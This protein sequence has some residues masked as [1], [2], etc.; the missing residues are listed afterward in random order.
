MIFCPNC[1]ADMRFDP[2]EQ[3][4]VCDYCGTKLTVE[5]ARTITA[6]LAEEHKDP[7]VN[8]EE[9]LQE[10]SG[11]QQELS[12][13][14]S[15]QTQQEKDSG[16]Q[17]YIYT[18]PQC[19]G[20]LLTTDDT[21]ATF[22]SYCGASVLLERRISRQ[23]RPDTILPFRK[24]KEDCEAA[25]RKFLGRTICLPKEVRDAEQI[26]KF[27]GIYMPYWLYDFRVQGHASGTGHTSERRGDFIYTHYYR[28]DTSVDGSFS[29]IGYDASSS[30]NDALS[31]AIEPFPI[32]EALPFEVSYLSG[33]YADTA[34]V[35]AAL[36]T[37]EAADQVRE[38]VGSRLAKE[39]AYSRHGI[40]AGEM[41]G[42]LPVE[43]TGEKLAYLPVWF[44]ASRSRDGS[45]VS[46]AVMN[47]QTGKLT[48]ELPVDF[49]KYLLLSLIPSLLLFIVFNFFLT[50]TP[51][52]LLGVSMLLALA[53]I[54]ISG[55]QMNQIYT[56]EHKLDDKGYQSAYGK[57]E[58][59]KAAKEPEKAVRAAETKTVSWSGKVLSLSV[60]V[61]LGSLALLFSIEVDSGLE[62]L[63]FGVTGISFLIMLL[64]FLATRIEKKL[65]R[66]RKKKASS[67]TLHS[68]E[69][70]RYQLLPGLGILAGAL[71]FFLAPAG[72]QYYYGAAG[73]IMLLTI[74]AFLA[75]VKQYN[76]LVSNPLPQFGKRGGD[77]SEI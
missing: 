29:G 52:V 71:V 38:H 17:T 27:R 4:L 60:L 40:D 7:S 35:P 74:L 53:A 15:A 58:D 49:R 1:K 2:A 36:Y 61:F 39:A 51:S 11:L 63:L 22:C 33:F 14:E 23:R 73:I 28:A 19:G 54:L 46:Y 72:D 59:R 26:D 30:F 25:Y 65:R 50:M 68:P 56:K 31:E 69:A 21:A 13:E 77:E 37:R 57:P 5:Q 34:D 3:K 47:G 76:R 8:Y 62:D 43:K 66:G 12:A 64:A 42:Q 6:R 9:S 16:Y 48:A 67:V 32:T 44:L 70:L 41:A 24:G 10:L 18:C 55:S 75:V 20:E 45:R